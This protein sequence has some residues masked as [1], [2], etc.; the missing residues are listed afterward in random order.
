M[1]A[2][3]LD[4]PMN[5]IHW[6]I[7]V[8]DS[9]WRKQRSLACGPQTQA[10]CDNSNAQENGTWLPRVGQGEGYHLPMDITQLTPRHSAGQ[11]TGLDICLQPTS[12]P[13]VLLA[14]D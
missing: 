1:E 14:T 5:H 11:Q 6:Q 7:T 10:S 2:E 4:D 9:L 12:G 3:C 8:E 13:T